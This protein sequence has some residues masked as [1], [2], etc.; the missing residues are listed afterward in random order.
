MDYAMAIALAGAAI[1]TFMAGIG[2]SIGLGIAGRAAA[3]VLAEKPERYGL[4]T[5]LV[6]LPSTQGIYGFV[7]SLFVMLKLNMFGGGVDSLSIATACQ[8][9]AGCLPVAVAGLFSGI[10]QGKACAGGIVMAAKRPDMGIKAGLVYAA[11]VE[12]YA[13]LGFLVSLLII[14]IGITVG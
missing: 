11:L 2:S 4:M 3:G 6:V 12:F 8:L 10:H 1:A 13:I 7:I 9:F 5:L 14:M